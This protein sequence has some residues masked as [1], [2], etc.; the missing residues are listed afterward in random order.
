[1]VEVAN[2]TGNYIKEVA[3][4]TDGCDRGGKVYR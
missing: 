4:D 3:R 1:M 2:Y